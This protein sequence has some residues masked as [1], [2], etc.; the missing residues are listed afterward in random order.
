MFQTV[1]L[2]R[3]YS[4]RSRFNPQ[5]LVSTVSLTRQYSLRSLFKL[6]RFVSTQFPLPGNTV[7]AHV[8]TQFPLPGNTVSAHVSSRNGSLNY[9][10]PCLARQCPHSQRAEGWLISP[11]DL[12]VPTL[13]AFGIKFTNKSTSHFTGDRD[14]PD[15]RKETQTAVVWNMSPVHQV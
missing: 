12:H 8:S 15:H 5:C 13:E 1:S 9:I 6:Q 3:Q 7:S 4:L 11:L 10:S 14:A 2:A